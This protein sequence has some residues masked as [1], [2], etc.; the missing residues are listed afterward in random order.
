MVRYIFTA[1]LTVIIVMFSVTHAG[2]KNKKNEHTSTFQGKYAKK[3]S[4]ESVPTENGIRTKKVEYRADGTI[5]EGYLAAPNDKRRKLRPAILIVHDWMG[6]SEF[7]RKKAQQLAKDGYIAFAV[8]IYG[9]GVRPHDQ[10]EAAETAGKY[11]NDR[12]LYRKRLRAAYDTVIRMNDVNA[13]KI[14]IIGYCFGGA[15]ALE[16]ARSGVPLAGTVTFHG[17]LNT[18]TPNEANKIKGPVLVL[19]GADD[20]KVPP[21]EVSA[22][23]EEM[24]RGNVN[25]EIIEYPDAVHSFTNPQA[26]NDKSSGS[27][28]NATADKESWQAFQDFLRKSNDNTDH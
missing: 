27:A 3:V 22:F 16:L 4:T 28:Y 19:H 24:K 8:D 5:L 12:N 18:P 17:S 21:Q 2:A 26:G 11:I 20:P 25:Y 7:T 14:F 1:L 23:R 10:K 6:P 9:K 13:K 15:G